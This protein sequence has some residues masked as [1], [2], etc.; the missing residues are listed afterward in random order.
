[1]ALKCKFIF[2]TVVKQFSACFFNDISKCAKY[3]HNNVF[4]FI[5]KNIYHDNLGC[6]SGYTRDRKTDIVVRTNEL[7]MNSSMFAED[8]DVTTMLLRK[9]KPLH[10]S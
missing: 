8:V 9:G 6:L 4:T 1:M 5:N 3:Q 7:K 2:K 10:L